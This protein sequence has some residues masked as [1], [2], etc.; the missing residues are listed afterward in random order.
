MEEGRKEGR[1]EEQRK[2]GRGE[3]GKDGWERTEGGREGGKIHFTE[4]LIWVAYFCYRDDCC[5]VGEGVHMD[6]RLERRKNVNRGYRKLRNWQMAIELYAFLYEKVKEIPD[7]PYRLIAQILDATS[8]VSANI[9]EGYCRRSLKE[10][11]NFLN[12][13]LA[14]A[15]EVYSRCYACY[16]AGQLSEITFDAI[17]ERHYA[18]ENALL[19]QIESLQA[20]Q[21]TG[22]WD[23]NLFLREDEVTYLLNQID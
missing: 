6:K 3:E 11:L 10:Y 16:R 1:L 12:I 13:A 7:R 21:Q 15:G 2:I 5:P 14:S 19:R 9:A 23:D 20:K 17:D 18:M 8:S 22:E 4:L